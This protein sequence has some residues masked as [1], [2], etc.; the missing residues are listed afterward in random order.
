MSELKSTTK[1]ASSREN[2][3]AQIK[4]HAHMIGCWFL[5]VNEKRQPRKIGFICTWVHRHRTISRIRFTTFTKETEPPMELT[6]SLLPPHVASLAHARIQLT[7]TSLFLASS[8]GPPLVLAPPSSGL[9][10][11]A[12]PA[13]GPALVLAEG[14]GWV[15]PHGGSNS[16]KEGLPD[17]RASQ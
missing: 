10:Q 3:L 15:R 12:A 11:I 2:K 9:Q 5:F 6:L 17:Q 4:L 13:Q 1:I 14:L 16:S 7:H 8:C